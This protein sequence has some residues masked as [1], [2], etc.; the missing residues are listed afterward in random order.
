MRKVIAATLIAGAALTATAAI[1]DNPAQFQ[2]ARIA[3]AL[4]QNTAGTNADKVSPASPVAA[5][6]SFGAATF[7]AISNSTKSRPH[8]GRDRYAP[9]SSPHGGPDR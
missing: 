2:E 3:A 7:D 6:I 8:F 9:P 4:A 1:A 5:V